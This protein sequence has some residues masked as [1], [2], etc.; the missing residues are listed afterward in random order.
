MIPWHLKPKFAQQKEEIVYNRYYHL[1]KV[2]E[3]EDLFSKIEGIEVI[4][5][6]YFKDNWYI[7][8]KKVK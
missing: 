2:G 7:T 3:L 4:N 6:Q 8:V 5:T 1:F